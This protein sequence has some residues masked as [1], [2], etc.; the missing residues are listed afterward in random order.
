MTVEE[1]IG[2]AFELGEQLTVIGHKLAPGDAAPDFALERFD[3]EAGAMQ[4]VRLADS[5]GA[6]RLLNVVNS[7]DTPVCHVETRQ[8]EHLRGDLPPGVTVYTISMDLPFAQA[9]WSTAEGVT[10]QALSTHK[11]EDFGRDY[12]VLLKEWRLLQRAVFV[13]NQADSIV[14]AEYVPDQMREP[15]YAAALAAVRQAAAREAGA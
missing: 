10:H 3:A 12:G 9:R 14:Y 2:E 11:S 5:A 7:L 13:I 4:Q 6:V 15:D 8:W 1:R